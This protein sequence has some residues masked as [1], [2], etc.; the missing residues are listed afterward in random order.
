MYKHILIGK[1]INNDIKKMAIIGFYCLC[2]CIIASP[3]FA[4]VP[5]IVREIMN[6][7]SPQQA[8]SIDPAI[9]DLQLSPG[10]TASY[11]LTIT[12]L[13]NKPLGI[14]T[15]LT[16]ID[17]QEN[18]YGKNAQ[19]VPMT[20]WTTLSESNLIIAPSEKKQITVK[21]TPPINTRDGGYYEA[22][23]LTPIVNNQHIRNEP[24]ILSRIGTLIFATIGKLNYQDLQKKVHIVNFAPTQSLFE[25]DNISLSFEV[26]N[27]YFTHFIAKPF[28]TITPL[29]F[30]QSK[31][32]LLEE[33]HILP[34]KTRRWDF[35]TRIQFGHII[36]KAHLAVFIGN[37]Q[38]VTADSLIFVLPYKQILLGIL[39]FT[40]LL[41]YIRK[42]TN[43]H[44]AI[45]ILI[46]GK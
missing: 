41:I 39:L 3:S 6:Q 9:S 1:N 40:I 23:F 15:A 33:K 11:I 16:D 4:M 42:K 26:T 36:Y 14:G 35:P 12:N 30:G 22:L 2:F 18:S 28:V 8:L 19:Q 7:Q 43:I 17:G 38:Q 13:S 34:S 32:T 20:I 46:R 25:N 29:F 31:T 27:D 44:K 45:E 24:V 10:K 21:I 5:G 37:G